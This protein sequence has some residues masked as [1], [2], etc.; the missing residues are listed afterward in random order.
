MK[1]YIRETRVTYIVTDEVQAN[2]FEEAENMPVNEELP[3]G[4]IS[5]KPIA[6]EKQVQ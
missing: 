2:S 4:A 1:T 3:E 5:D 6:I